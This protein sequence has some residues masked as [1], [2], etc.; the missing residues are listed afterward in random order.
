M[1]ELERALGSRGRAH[2]AVAKQHLPIDL[3]KEKSNTIRQVRQDMRPAS[4]E[5]F[6]DKGG[7]TSRTPL[8]N[9]T[10]VLSPVAHASP[11]LPHPQYSVNFQKL[12]CSQKNSARLTSDQSV[13]ELDSIPKFQ[14]SNLVTSEKSSS[15]SAMTCGGQPLVSIPVRKM[16]GASYG[17]CASKMSAQERTVL[18]SLPSIV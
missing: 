15:P 10:H 7:A 13:V 2:A 18:G 5:S 3:C 4:A 8:Q 12:V 16:K 11:R 6:S 1:S 9:A 17:G 14:D